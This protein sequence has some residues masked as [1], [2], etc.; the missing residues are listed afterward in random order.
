M[1]TKSSDID[2]KLVNGA[3]G[4][5]IG[6]QYCNEKIVVVCIEFNDRLVGRNLMKSDDIE[7]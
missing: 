3:L 1:L 4:K 6:F 7:K 2:D 5:I